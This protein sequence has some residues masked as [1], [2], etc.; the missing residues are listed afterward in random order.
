M[1]VSQSFMYI[2]ALKNVQLNLDANAYTELRKLIEAG[3]RANFKYAIYAALF[4]NLLLV[5]ST[6]KT[7][8]AY[9]LAQLQLLLLRWSPTRC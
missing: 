1:I 8:G 6:V 9:C 3:M 5:I 4:G 2:L 7:P